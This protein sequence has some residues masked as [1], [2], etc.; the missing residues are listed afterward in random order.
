VAAAIL[1]EF[2]AGTEMSLVE[3]SGGVFDVTSDG[4]IV[5]SKQ[6]LGIPKVGEVDEKAVVAAI[7]GD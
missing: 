3:G 2:P 6:E 7:R 5:F 4:E 1:E